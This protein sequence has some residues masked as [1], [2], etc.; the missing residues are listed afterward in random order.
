MVLGHIDQTTKITN[1][2]KSDDSWIFSF[3]LPHD[4]YKH[5]SKKVQ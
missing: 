2:I 4:L 3:S 1:I 5:I